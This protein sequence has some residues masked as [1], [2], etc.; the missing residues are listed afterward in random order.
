MSRSRARRQL[1]TPPCFFPGRGRQRRRKLAP[2]ADKASVKKSGR[3]GARYWSDTPK[4][5]TAHTGGRPPAQRAAILRQD[6]AG[7]TRRVAG[8]GKAEH[9]HAGAAIR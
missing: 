1:P 8:T 3:R 5:D 7:L 2:G 6:G 4:N 9:T